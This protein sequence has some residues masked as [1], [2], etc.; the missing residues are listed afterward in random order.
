MEES[1]DPI[2]FAKDKGATLLEPERASIS[3]ARKVALTSEKYKAGSMSNPM[4][5][6]SIY[7]R[8][9]EYPGHHF[10]RVE[11]KLRCNACHEFIAVKKSTVQKHVQSRKHL[12]GI[13]NIQRDKLKCQ[14]IKESL[15]KQVSGATLSS[16]VRVFRFEVV[17]TLLLAGIPISKIDYLRP[18]FEKYG[19]SLTASTHMK[20]I[21]PS[22]L[23]KEQEKLKAELQEVKEVSVIFDGTARLG[24]ALA[25]VVRYIKQDF[26]PTQRLVCLEIL[27]KP[28]KGVELAQRLMSNIAVKHNFGSDT[29]IA[30]M[31]DGASVNG[32]AIKQLLFFYPNIM[33]VVCFSHTID[34][35]GSH[36]EFQILDVFFQYWVSLFA[37]SFNAK[38]LWRERTGLSM[39]SHSKTP[40]WSKWEILKQVSDY[41][42][43]VLPF[44]E[45]NASL[46]PITR[47][48][49]LDIFSNPQDLQDLRLELAAIV[50]AGVYFVKS[51]YNL[52]G[53][54]PLIFSCYEHLSAV[55]QAVGI[56]HYP[57]TLAVARDIANGDV[58]LQNRLLAQAKA[59]IQPGLTFF[60]EKFSLQFRNTVRAFKV[61]RLCCPVQV[62]HLLPNAA[63]LQEFKN[64]PFVDDNTIDNLAAELPA[65][66]AAADGTA[67]DLSEM[68]KLAW[69]AGHSDTLPH[70][71][72]LVRKLL[73]I[74]PSSAASERVFSLLATLSS[75][76]DNALVD[77]IE[78]SVMIRYNECQRKA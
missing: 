36:F 47:Q 38:L 77:Y 17:E 39:K 52:E 55:A 23:T 64:F 30:A 49:L 28:L 20:D 26:K 3:R 56:G 14:S 65:Y 53:D 67:A 61:A 2:Q 25:I 73:L 19:H 13:D 68:Q 24:E 9:K 31:R 6:T 35:V 44:L 29:V 22:V 33:D 27:A 48:H 5:K 74:Q 59:C 43:D 4:S 7:D 12:K 72:S 70:W 45:E 42:G 78:A 76:Q 69:W 11:G 21:I 18:L 46:S 50:D 10:A 60:Q 58:A 54:G 8:I 71:A 16:N 15:Q 62:Q 40:W 34:N 1:E 32:A 66:L 51:T 75:Q 37:H 57:C 63:A 41:F